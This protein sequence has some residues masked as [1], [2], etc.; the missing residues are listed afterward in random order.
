MTIAT[1]VFGA[2][3]F[4]TLI[5]LS[6]KLRASHPAN[7]FV[8]LAALPLA[9]FV[10]GIGLK[11]MPS[12]WP[13]IRYHVTDLGAPVF[14]ATVLLAPR[15]LFTMWRRPGRILRAKRLI[16]TLQL[17]RIAVVLGLLTSYGYDLISSDLHRQAVIF[18]NSH[19]G[20]PAFIGSF[21]LVDMLCFTIGATYTF[22]YLTVGIIGTRYELQKMT[23]PSALGRRMPLS[24]TKS[25]P[26]PRKKRIRPSQTGKRN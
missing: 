1:L 21:D 23:D 18:T 25:A 9:V 8:V 3:W 14:I 7:S 17:C 16:F 6:K 22:W 4:L 13:F 20:G 19:G 24:F 12:I 2:V 15:L 10:M 26:K 5:I 11:F